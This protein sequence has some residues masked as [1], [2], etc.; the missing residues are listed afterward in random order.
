[1]KHNDCFNNNHCNKF[2][3][4]PDCCNNLQTVP[5][6]S[7]QISQLIFLLNSLI[8]AIAAFFV[9][10]SDAN[11]LVLINLFNQLLVL[12]QSL[13]PS[14]EGNYLI[15]LIQSI[16]LLLQ[17][18]T[19][20]L[21][22][23]A[24]LLQQFYSALATF[25]FTLIVDSSV[26]QLLLNLVIQLIN[27]TPI[28]TGVTGAT[29]PTGDPGATGATGAT[30]APGETVA[31]GPTGPT[32]ATG[33]TGPTGLTGATGPTGPLTVA[34]NATVSNLAT[35]PVAGNAS[36][37]FVTNNVING[38]AISHT[39][40]STDIVLAPNQTYYAIW[41][42]N[43]NSLAAGELRAFALY[44]N[45]TQLPASLQSVANAGTNSI[46]QPAVGGSTVFNTG[47]GANILTLEN[48]LATATTISAASVTVIKLI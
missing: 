4:I 17:S 40:G 35:I 9:N 46:I 21:T 2:S 12:I 3:F 10:P 13:A 37:P 25:F 8:A 43:A 16:L 26:L 6:T 48:A 45:G 39:A 20:N 44:L 5:I 7:Q 18:P 47:A 23:I 24:I 19:P 30:G 36:V 28:P 42:S 11:R 22:Q 34:N 27:V 1:M 31:T 15:Q 14:P 41:N 38:T 29:G 32:G 33:A